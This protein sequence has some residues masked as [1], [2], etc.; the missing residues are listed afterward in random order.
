RTRSRRSP[1]WGRRHEDA[2]ERCPSEYPWT[3]WWMTDSG[4]SKPLFIPTLPI[5]LSGWRHQPLDRRGDVVPVAG[6]TA[7]PDPVGCGDVVEQLGR[8]LGAPALGA[9]PKR[10]ALVQ[11][12]VRLQEL[13]EERQTPFQPPR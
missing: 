1:S 9:H 6:R 8:L 3:A 10:A 5:E 4:E 7:H 13:P 11:V 2:N 12:G